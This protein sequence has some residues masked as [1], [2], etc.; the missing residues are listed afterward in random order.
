MVVVLLH[1]KNCRN[2]LPARST[3][4]SL[5]PELGGDPQLC[6]DSSYIVSLRF[7]SLEP[8]VCYSIE[9]FLVAGCAGVT[10]FFAKE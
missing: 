8:L 10:K 2:D 7:S 9:F 6:A 1:A 4:C 3:C 5:I